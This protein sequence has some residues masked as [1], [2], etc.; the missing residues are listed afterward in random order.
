MNG[1]HSLNHGQRKA[2]DGL[3]S[4]PPVITSRSSNPPRSSSS[5]PTENPV[6]DFAVR[7]EGTI[8]LFTPQTAAAFDFLSEHI[9]EDAQYFGYSLA[10]EH[11]FV[12][13]LLV[14]LRDHGL[15]AVRG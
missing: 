2:G 11:R 6:F 5:S 14:G 12:H 15:E 10:V 4:S 3:E 1:K 13:D 7:D 8:W 9:Q